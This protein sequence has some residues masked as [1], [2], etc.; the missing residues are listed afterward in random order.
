MPQFQ[1]QVLQR[2]DGMD[3]LAGHAHVAAGPS[4]KVGER[5]DRRRGTVG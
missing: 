1:K 3:S 2:F 4:R 5:G